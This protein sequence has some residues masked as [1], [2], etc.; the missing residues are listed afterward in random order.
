MGTQYDR[1]PLK[2]VAVRT[3]QEPFDPSNYLSEM[4]LPETLQEAVLAGWRW[5]FVEL[6][7]GIKTITAAMLD[8]RTDEELL[9]IKGVGPAAL[10]ELRRAVK[11]DGSLNPFW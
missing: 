3:E 4:G 8:E 5:E 10:A 2:V 11:K 6:G 9:S 1:Y 7:V